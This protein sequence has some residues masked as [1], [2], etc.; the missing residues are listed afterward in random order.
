MFIF[1]LLALSASRS[2]FYWIG[3]IDLI[4]CIV[5]I[6]IID[7]SKS[8]RINLVSRFDVVQCVFFDLP[9]AVAFAN[10]NKKTKIEINYFLFLASFV[11]FSPFA[12]VSSVVACFRFSFF[13]LIIF[14]CFARNSCVIKRYGV[15]YSLSVKYLYNTNDKQF[16][17]AVMPFCSCFIKEFE[18]K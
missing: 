5:V 3:G 7:F 18:K 9:L 10:Y 8:S 1:Y 6:V 12:L 4:V 13:F 11:M 16:V 17:A 14:R 15:V 2:F